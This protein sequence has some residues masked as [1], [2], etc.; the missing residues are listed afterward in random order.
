M[1]CEVCFRSGG[2]KLPF[3]CATDARNRLYEPRINHARVLVERDAL[4]QQITALLATRPQQQDAEQNEGRPPVAGPAVARV[5]A[6]RE[7]AADRTQQ[8]LAHAEELRFNVE[9]A[10]EEIAKKKAVLERRKSDL[11]SATDGVAAR[12][13][14]QTEEA[15]KAIRMAKYKWN[16]THAVTASSRAFLCGEAARLYGLRRVRKNGSLE[17]Y[18]IGGIGIV[19]LRTMNSK[20]SFTSC[21]VHN[22]DSMMQ[23]QARLRSPQLC[24][25]SCIF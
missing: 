13:T 10:R 5:H 6:E 22:T 16:Q 3:L 20:A 8:I 24:H 19:D 21:E 7:Q 25:T 1:Q 23:L 11:A 2:P 18:R 15:E 17:E 9:K 4:D 12:R 14:R